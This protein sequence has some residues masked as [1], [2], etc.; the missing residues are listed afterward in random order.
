MPG[1]R[2]A[3]GSAGRPSGRRG[4]SSALQ[5][6][7][8]S[9]LTSHTPPQPAPTAQPTL[10]PDYWPTEVVAESVANG[11]LLQGVLRLNLTNAA[12]GYVTIRGI[13]HDLLVKVIVNK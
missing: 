11:Q 13:R 12:E 9:A 3:V 10:Y 1:P 5:A 7:A 8:S 2:D 4:K 6:I